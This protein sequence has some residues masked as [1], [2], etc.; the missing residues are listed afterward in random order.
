[1]LFRNMNSIIR[2][3]NNEFN[4]LRKI[5]SLLYFEKLFMWVSF[6]IYENDS[7]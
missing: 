2:E 7:I 1:M 6:K 5:V 4:L 3:K